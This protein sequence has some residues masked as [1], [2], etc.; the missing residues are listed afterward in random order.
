[1]MDIEFERHIAA[2]PDIV[3]GYFTDPERYTRWMGVDAS[4]DPRPGGEYRVV[5]P[6]GAVTSGRFLTLEPP[7]KIQFTWG[8]EG[9][10][11]V[12]PGSSTVTVTF[13]ATEGGTAL[14]LT[15]SGLPTE[16]WRLIHTSGWHLYL[17]RLTIVGA[18]GDPG[19]LEEGT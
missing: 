4:I 18:G 16:E 15:H 3:Y 1:M 10:P 14:R 9:N 12:P 7:S 17:D 13:T 2:P 11:D 6:N 5:N 8:F 19:P